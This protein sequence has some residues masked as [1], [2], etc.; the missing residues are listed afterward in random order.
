VDPYNLD[1]KLPQR[2]LNLVFRILPEFVFLAVAAGNL[3]VGHSP[4]VNPERVVLIR[5]KFAGLRGSIHRG[6]E[7]HRQYTLELAIPIGSSSDRQNERH[8][9]TCRARLASEIFLARL[10]PPR[11]C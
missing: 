7:T 10:R 3:V 8:R 1:E 6:V 11:C 9:R 2:V 4:E 5:K